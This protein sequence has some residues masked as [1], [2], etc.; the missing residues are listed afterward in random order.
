[1][2]YGIYR[3]AGWGGLLFICSALITAALY[4]MYRRA[5]G[6]PYL[7]TLATLLAGASSSPLFGIRPQMITFLFASIYIAILSRFERDGRSRQLWWMAAMM[8][9]WVN[10][11]AG[12]ALGVALIGLYLVSFVIDRKWQLLRPMALILL[13]CTAIVPL[14]PNGFRMFSYRSRP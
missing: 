10:F 12:Y 3:V 6:K 4:I 9:L 7:A 1:M 2:I 14:N 13:V 8:L 11:H 5:D